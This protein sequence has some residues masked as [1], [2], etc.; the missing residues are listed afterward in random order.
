MNRASRGED[1]VGE[2][3][4]MLSTCRYCLRLSDAEVCRVCLDHR[5][6]SGHFPSEVFWRQMPGHGERLAD[7]AASAELSCGFLPSR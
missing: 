4:R 3:S 2:L 7:F 5:K 1:A 6:T